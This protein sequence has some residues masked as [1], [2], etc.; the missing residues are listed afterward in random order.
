MRFNRWRRLH[1]VIC[2]LLATS[3]AAGAAWAYWSAE[4]LPGGGGGATAA[5][6][7]RGTV[8]TAVVVGHFVTLNWGATT[9]TTGTPV[10]GYL[11]KR[12]SGTSEQ[13]VLAGCAGTITVLTCTETGVP[14]GIWTYSVTAL[15]AANWAGAESDRSA[16]VTVQNGAPTAAADNYALTE[17]SP[18]SV[19]S[20][21]VLAN[22]ADPE[23]DAL[24]AV[25]V[26]GP[27]H[28]T[29]AL[30]AD[31]TFTYTP[32]ANFNGT[33]TFRYKANDGGS[34]SNV[35]SVTLTVGA[36]NDAPANII[37]AAQQTPKNTSRVFSSAN[38]NP[39]SVS[40]ADAAGSTVQVILTAGSGAVTLPV[41]TGLTF[42]AGD[43]TSD[44]TMTFTG[45]IATI[46]SRLSG[47]TFVPT[48]NFTGAASLQIVTSDLGNTGT[49]GAL[50]ATGS[51]TIN[52]SALGI[53]AVNQ[54][55]GAPLLAGSSSYSGG[56]YTVAGSG[57]GIWNSSDQFQFLS[58]PMTGDGRLTA[59]VVSQN[60][61]PVTV[62][63][64]KAG[65]MF[66]QTTAAGSIHAMMDVMKSNGSEFHW[67][68]ATDGAS[69]ATTVTAGIAAP[70]WV[71]I[72]RIGN[73]VIG[74]RS[75]NGVTWVQQGAS[76]T[77][78]MGSAI[79]AGLAVS[80]V[81]NVS[82]N[83]AVF[84]NVS[85]TTPP[86]A[87]GG[88]YT[89]NEDTAISASAPGVL[90]DD[91]DPESNSL[92]AVLV[93]GTP[94]LTLNSDGSFNYLPPA[95]F[96]GVASF[97]Y[98]ANDGVFDSNTVTVN[99]IVN[100]S[101]EVP[102]F[103]KGADQTVPSN[104]G[105]QLLPSWATS[106]STG[107]GESGQTASF[108]ATNNNPALFTVQPSVSGTGTL[109]YTPAP[110][111]AGVATVILSLQDNGGTA[112]GGLDTSPVQTFTI[113]VG[114]A[115]LLATTGTGLAYTENGSSFLDSAITISDADSPTLT[116]ADV[117][118]TTNYVNGQDA[119]AFTNQAGITGTWTAASGALALSGT[120]NVAD[121][122]AALRS[123]TYSNSSN[124]PSTA[125]RTVSFTASDGI[126]TSIPATRTVSVTS[127]NDAPGNT[128][129]ASQTTFQ[130]TPAVFTISNGNAI[131]TAD[132]DASSAQVQLISTNGTSTLSGTAGLTFTTGDGTADA[133]MSFTGTIT[134][135]NTAL[136]GLRFAP[137]SNF[138]GT[139]TLQMLT[140]DLGSTGS[141]GVLTDN[142]TFNIMVTPG[143]FTDI[144]NVGAG[145]AGP[146]SSTYSA[147]TYTE[148]GNGADIWQQDQFHYLYK[149]WTGDGTIIARV[150][151]L[152]TS[153]KGAK[154]AVMFRESVNTDSKHAMMALQPP[155]GGGAEWAYRSS[156]TQTN[157]TSTAGIKPTYWIKLVRSGDTFTGFTAP[158][159]SGTPGTWTQRGTQSIP[160][161]DTILVG[162]ATLSHSATLT[163]T[164]TY[165]NVMVQ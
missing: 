143:I 51:V 28:G 90:A 111:A 133:T 141:G 25:L 21:A 69:G 83:T 53:F 82:V 35:A 93:S 121:Y 134:A 81:S 145:T 85:L 110:Q 130:N 12:Y 57:S 158:D 125:P 31:G 27:A 153:H 78:T 101:N 84:D 42:S 50:S 96:S 13:T 86:L 156:G 44:G 89:T 10:S 157:Y 47:L 2:L 40:D 151:S 105:S 67:R 3:L 48:S 49:G 71:R 164:A 14:A 148:V 140:S 88:S 41:L 34:D 120:A 72:T 146:T 56:T 139:A 1:W 17:D 66:R 5:S 106:I 77:V 131:S 11:V 94:G 32:E 162:L 37:P 95:N 59:K 43:G 92:T 108:T 70:Y 98:K 135:I 38:N 55:V 26:T 113:S 73:L 30:R 118:L 60:Q 155:T 159:A 117:T 80:A 8:P 119:L 29:I 79:Q 6:V 138:T 123:I 165:D 9:L 65:V 23:A 46:N 91:S 128:V 87:V 19:T 137:Q 100:P 132:P 36:V 33:D 68:L 16:A 127:V 61:S 24:S 7:N 147:G 39:V 126:F 114:A 18:L 163:T 115:P 102:S 15:F 150:T 74:E 54:D 20:G 122:Q 129:P 144:I 58:R 64:A 107:A 149:F 22:D 45:P 99:I 124:N 112:F 154:A 136:A 76:Q 4:S 62:G 109:S 116:S 161:P 152:S 52:V 142:D 63:P 160:M 104:S 103:I 75:A 97:T